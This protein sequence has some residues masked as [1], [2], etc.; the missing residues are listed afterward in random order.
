MEKGLKIEGGD[1]LGKTIIFAKNSLHAQAIVERFNKLFPEYGGDFIK[2][3]DYSIKYSDSLIDEFSTS[4][5]MPQIAVSVDMLDTGI[6]IP[7]IL[8][9]VFFKK[10]KSY[11][12][13]WQMIGRGT[14]LCPNLLGEGMDKER[15]LIFDFCNNFEYFRVN[16]NGAENG[17][18]ESLNEKIYNTKAQIVRELQAPVYSSDEVYADYRKSL[19]D[20]LKEDV[21]GLN[22][23]SFMVKRHLRYVEF[24]RA[25][26]SWD[27][28][29][30]IEISDIR[31]HIAPLIRPKK[32]DELA[33]RFDYLVY[34]IDLGLLQS[35]KH[36]KSGE[37][38][39][40]DGRKAVCKILNPT[41]GKEKGDYRKGSD[42]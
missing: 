32:E 40:S 20:D 11:A 41:G 17:I 15:F 2:R 23:D 5:K 26:S 42:K 36:T 19:V 4:D 6:D 8:N 3:I 33:R 27:N 39:G 14:R 31:E 16:K 9:L 18:T 35:K 10:V 37:Y 38:S 34:S 21:I 30:T 29:E 28:L 25:S 13:F 24:F 22:G 7:E 12:K 1:K